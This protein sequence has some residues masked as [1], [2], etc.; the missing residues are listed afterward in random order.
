MD[1]DQLIV[2]CDLGTTE[3]RTL[4]AAPVDGG[5]LQVLGVG[6]AETAGFRDG[7]FV[8][9]GSGSRALARSVRLAE[10]DADVDITGFYYGIS[11]SHLRSVWARGRHQIGPGRRTVA[12][13]DIAAVIERAN[14]IAIPFDHAILATN[15]V[16][17]S[18]DGIDGIVDP[19]DR[20]GSMLEVDAYLITGSR[21][22]QNSIENTIER[23]GYQSVGW[24]IDALAAAHAL[25]SPQE[26]R[27]GV[28]LIDVGGQMTQWVV[29]RSGRIAGSG[30]VPWGGVH[31]T[32]DLAHGLR[33]GQNTAEATKRERGLVLRSLA[34]DEVDVDVLFDEDEVEATPGLI[35][36]ILEPRLEEIFRLVRE[37]MG[38]A[39]EPGRLLRGAVVTGGGARCEGTAELCEEVLGLPAQL[40]FTPAGLAGGRTL[41]EGQWATAVGLAFWALSGDEPVEP[42]DDAFAES[43]GL[44]GFIRGLFRRR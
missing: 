12:D 20:P 15:P 44:P 36:A 37:D 31:M 17:F 5:G 18:V 7:D 3:F 16:A 2:V 42:E 22:V 39:F 26:Q 41:P 6:L 28:V 4:V 21:S 27:D 30:M 40:R 9:I 8:D 35:A 13:A 38:A 24:R 25:L 29:F 43:G 19:L 11:G 33:V 10:S 1:Y 23:A 34:R 32:N 14:S